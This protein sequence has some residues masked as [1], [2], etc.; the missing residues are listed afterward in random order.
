MPL[1]LALTSVSKSSLD[2]LH[3]PSGPFALRPGRLDTMPLSYTVHLR[4][5]PGHAAPAHSQNASQYT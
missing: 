2:P 5:L 3:I 1:V 4:P